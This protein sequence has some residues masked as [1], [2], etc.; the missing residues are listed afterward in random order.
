M[1]FRTWPHWG[2][3]LAWHGVLTSTRGMSLAYRQLPGSLNPSHWPWPCCHG[4]VWDMCAWWATTGV[5]VSV[6]KIFIPICWLGTQARERVIRFQG[7]SLHISMEASH[8]VNA[9]LSDQ[10]T[11]VASPFPRQ[12]LSYAPK[13]R[14]GF[15]LPKVRI[16]DSRLRFRD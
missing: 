13:C 11:L 5:R 10:F 1:K 15:D 2:R 4:P 7:Q 16:W 9:F 12:S 8:F 6:E 14:K 3:V